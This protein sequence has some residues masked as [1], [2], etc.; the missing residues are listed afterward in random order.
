MWNLSVNNTVWYPKLVKLME[1]DHLIISADIFF[2][3]KHWNLA[4]ISIALAW[5]NAWDL[6]PE[7]HMQNIPL[8]CSFSQSPGPWIPHIFEHDRSVYW[9]RDIVQI[10]LEFKCGSSSLRGRETHKTPRSIIIKAC[11]SAAGPQV[12]LVGFSNIPGY[13]MCR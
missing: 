7:R 5:G 2:F 3:N 6:S 10:V 4:S 13:C 11:I 12:S 8:L 1:R 9:S